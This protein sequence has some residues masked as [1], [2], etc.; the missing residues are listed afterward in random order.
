MTTHCTG[1]EIKIG[2]RDEAD[3]RDR[4]L[5]HLDLIGITVRTILDV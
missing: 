1:V 4:I 2:V 3:V 5:H